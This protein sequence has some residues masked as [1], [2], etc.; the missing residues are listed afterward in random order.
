MPKCITLKQLKRKNEQTKAFPATSL[1]KAID[2][3]GFSA[4]GL[5]VPAMCCL[6]KRAICAVSREMA[7]HKELAVKSNIVVYLYDPHSS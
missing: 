4:G 5:N 3:A 1:R 6:F 2:V 7:R